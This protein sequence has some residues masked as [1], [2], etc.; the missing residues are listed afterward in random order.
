MITVLKNL[1]FFVFCIYSLFRG[2]KPWVNFATEKFMAFT[3]IVNLMAFGASMPTASMF[4]SKKCIIV[5]CFMLG[6][7]V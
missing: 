3:G 5:M 1:Y 2:R 7:A 6:L 4:E